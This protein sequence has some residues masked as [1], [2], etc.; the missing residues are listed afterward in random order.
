[1]EM[2]VGGSIYL[3]GIASQT[4]IY[5]GTWVGRGGGHSESIKRELKKGSKQGCR[6][7]WSDHCR[8]SDSLFFAW[9]KNGTVQASRLPGEFHALPQ[10]VCMCAYVRTAKYA[11]ALLKERGKSKL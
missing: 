11:V 3:Q 10:R 8:D 7:E 5:K 1:M 4:P 9:L 6:D 2:V